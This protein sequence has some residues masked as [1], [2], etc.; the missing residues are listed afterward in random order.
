[1]E[2]KGEI[3]TGNWLT[4]EVASDRIIYYHGYYF[5]T[6]DKGHRD[7]VVEYYVRS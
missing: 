3:I 5:M 1:M 2:A 4:K 7:S 6:F